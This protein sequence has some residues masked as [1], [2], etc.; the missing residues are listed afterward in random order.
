[1]NYC[2]LSIF[3]IAEITLFYTIYKIVKRKYVKCYEIFILAITL[4]IIK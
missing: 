1:M 3:I 2:L 4:S